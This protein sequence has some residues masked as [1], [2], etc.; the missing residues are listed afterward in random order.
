MS[1]HLNSIKRII[2]K[3]GSSS[4]SLISETS[5]MDPLDPTNITVFQ[6][7]DSISCYPCS[8]SAYYITNGIV[9]LN[10]I[11]LIIDPSTVS[12]NIND[13]IKCTDGTNTYNVI[14]RKKVI[15]KDEVVLY[16]LQIR[17]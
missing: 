6:S 8:Y 3:H 16:E 5:T 10:D 13:V 4:W 15:D 11:K 2:S 9:Q 7:S 1:I 12:V 14:N 17:I